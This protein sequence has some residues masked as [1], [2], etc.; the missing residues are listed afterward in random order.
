MNAV[1]ASLVGLKD[2]KN[3]EPELRTPNSEPNLNT[4]REVSMEKL[5]RYNS[6][7]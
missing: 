7:Q 5:E 3:R 2:R 1:F 4:N 6:T